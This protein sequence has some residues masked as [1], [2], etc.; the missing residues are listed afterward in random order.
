MPFNWKEGLKLSALGVSALV[1][2][3]ALGATGFIDVFTSSAAVQTAPASVSASLENSQAQLTC[4][5]HGLAAD[6]ADTIAGDLQA[7]GSMNS[8]R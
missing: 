1:C 8:K 7:S 2:A 3:G 5:P 6:G 4:V